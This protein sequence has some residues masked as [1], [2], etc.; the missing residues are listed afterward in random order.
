[1]TDLPAAAESLELPLFAA[2]GELPIE[3]GPAATRLLSAF[4]S[5]RS[6]RDAAQLAGLT[7]PRAYAALRTLRRVRKVVRCGRSA[8]I[9]IP[10]R[11][12]IGGEAIAAAPP[13]ARLLVSLSANPRNAAD[14]AAEFNMPIG[15][16]RQTVYF[17]ARQ[18]LVRRI[19]YGLYQANGADS[20]T[21]PLPQ[22][23]R[24][25]PIADRIYELLTEPRR[26]VELRPLVDRPI[27]TITGHLHAMMR[28][29]RVCR[30]R[31]GLYARADWVPGNNPQSFTSKG[32]IADV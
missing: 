14:L 26:P 16:V 31:T 32:A 24:P 8:Y 9:Q 13:I 7:L 5:A 11:S 27:P 12:D 17:L 18:G 3:L 25:S 4:R 2:T 10:V 19:G 28:R 23:Q 1:M 6:L 29:G 22:I 21:G 15:T 20:I 30:L